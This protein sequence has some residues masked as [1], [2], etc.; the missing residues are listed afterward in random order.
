MVHASFYTDYNDICYLLSD[1]CLMTRY[2]IE[3]ICLDRELTHQLFG[4]N[5]LLPRVES[6]SDQNPVGLVSFQYVYA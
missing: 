5:S 4:R 6:E 2:L 3:N 1:L